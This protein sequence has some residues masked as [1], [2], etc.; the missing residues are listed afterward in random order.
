MIFH[1]NNSALAKR[2]AKSLKRELSTLGVEATLG[3]CQNA[4]ANM[5]GFANWHE[6]EAD[7]GRH[8][9][10][11]DDAAAPPQEVAIRR[12]HHLAVMTT[13][14]PQAATAAPSIVDAIAR[15]AWRPRLARVPKVHDVILHVVRDGEYPGAALSWVSEDGP[16]TCGLALWM[17][18]LWAYS[19]DARFTETEVLSAALTE[20]SNEKGGIRLNDNLDY[21]FLAFGFRRDPDWRD[22]PVATLADHPEASHARDIIRGMADKAAL[23]VVSAGGISKMTMTRHYAF[24]ADHGPMRERRHAFASKYPEF[25]THVIGTRD[26]VSA[27]DLHAD[28]DDAMLELLMQQMVRRSD[29]GM[30]ETA[31]ARMRGARWDLKFDSQLGC[32][33]GVLA[34]IPASAIPH[35]DRERDALI[36]LCWHL[37]HAIEDQVPLCNDY[38]AGLATTIPGKDWSS[39]LAKWNKDGAAGVERLARKG[40]KLREEDSTPQDPI[41]TFY[42]NLDGTMAAFMYG[43]VKPTLARVNETV[44][45]VHLSLTKG[46]T[47]LGKGNVRLLPPTAFENS[48]A[49]LFLEGISHREFVALMEASHLFD[50]ARGYRSLPPIKDLDPAKIAARFDLCRHLLRPQ[51]RDVTGE[52]AIAMSLAGL[53]AAGQQIADPSMIVHATDADDDNAEA[54]FGPDP[55]RPER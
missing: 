23:G 30:A 29:I 52:T 4:V 44:R 34:R 27:S 31:F 1:A 26:S 19:A 14:F 32:L 20:Q 36:D 49:P 11:P 10:S 21:A 5:H 48:C 39:K 12:L 54:N 37:E 24:Y 9:P 7:L 47:N 22:E 16:E 35:T 6:M 51:H 13:S 38:A 28:P 41:D 25:A 50:R 45:H 33:G 2:V 17:G 8:E 43:A 55:F 46:G 40:I 42:S 15:T 53:K 3:Q 18:N